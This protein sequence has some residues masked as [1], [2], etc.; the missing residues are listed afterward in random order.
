[1]ATEIQSHGE[2]REW[3]PR[4]TNHETVRISAIPVLQQLSVFD[5][6]E[7]R[8]PDVPQEAAYVGLKPRRRLRR[9]LFGYFL[10]RYKK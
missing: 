7:V 6:Q 1:M 2:I 8:R 4:R 5:G 10:F 3:K 9:D